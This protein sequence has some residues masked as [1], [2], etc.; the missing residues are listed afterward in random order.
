MLNRAKAELSMRMV[1][2]GFGLVLLGVSALYGAERAAA[3]PL[4]PHRA[5][6]DLKLVSVSD[7]SDIGALSGRWV[8]DFSGNACEG[9][10]AE[11]RLVMRFETADG[12]RLIDRRVSTF[13]TGDGRSFK[14]KSESYADDELEQEV[15]G[16]ATLG[17]DGVT[18]QY[19]KPEKVE[20]EFGAAKFPTSQVIEMMDKVREGKR[21]YESAVFDGTEM[22]DDAVL[23]SVVVGRPKE[24]TGPARKVLGDLGKE[25]FLPVTMAYFEPGSEQEG[26]HISDYDVSFRM[27]ENGVQTD[28]VIRYPDYSMAADLIEF[29]PGKIDTS[30]TKGPKKDR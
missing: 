26:E 13:E 6:Y 20:V 15:E 18:V 7:T 17:G 3:A 14:F 24:L 2:H 5:V 1:R 21:F 19:T 28:I 25:K 10:T 16:S 9:Y 12:S 30:C 22:V 29:S 4:L 8:F 27:H 23:V 11:S